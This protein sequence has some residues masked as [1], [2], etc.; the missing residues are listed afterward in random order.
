MTQFSELQ[1][2]VLAYGFADSKYRVNVGTWLNEA[3]RKIAAK[4][5]M[6]TFFEGIRFATS[7]FDVSVPDDFLR[8]IEVSLSTDATDWTPLDPIELRDFDDAPAVN[9]TPTSY[10]IAGTVL[11]LYPYPDS[12]VDVSFVYYRQPIDMEDDADTPEISDVYEDVMVAWALKRAYEREQDF[13]AAAYHQADFNEQMA[14][15][16]GQLQTDT[17]TPPKIVPGMWARMGQVIGPVMP[18]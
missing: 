2:R 9:G 12:E 1:D 13:E 11:Y 18:R 7:Q 4:A 17:V 6:R 5:S 8:V 14:E 3:Q 16:M 15:L 10:V